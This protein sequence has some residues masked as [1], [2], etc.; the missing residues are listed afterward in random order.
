VRVRLCVCVCVCVCVFV[1][2]RAR[3]QLGSLVKSRIHSHVATYVQ[4]LRHDNLVNLLEVFRRK[5]RLYLVFEYVDHTLLDDLEANELYGLSTVRAPS[6][7]SLTLPYWIS[8]CSPCALPLR[9]L[10]SHILCA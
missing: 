2:T 4:M 1:F 10:H 6:L 9:A 8:L 7:P 3:S 5:K